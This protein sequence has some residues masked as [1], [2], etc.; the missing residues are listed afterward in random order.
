MGVAGAGKTTVGRALG[1]A[2]EWTF[3]DADDYHSAENVERMRS[4]VALTDADRAPWLAALRTAIETA[5]ARGDGVVVACSALK[6]TYRD[7]LVPAGAARTT[8]FVFLHASEEL[9]RRRLAAREGHYAGVALA[10]SQLGT[11]EE[12]R[13]ALRVDA[14]AAPAAIVATIRSTFGLTLAR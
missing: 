10:E 8:R 4:G 6:Q 9:V 12:P 5:L 3:I 1:S 13:D 11:L 14:A 2:L 7:V